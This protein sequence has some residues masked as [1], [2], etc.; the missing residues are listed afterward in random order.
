MT[1]ETKQKLLLIVILSF[2]L[3]IIGLSST[4][5]IIYAKLDR[6]Q[7]DTIESISCDYPPPKECTK[8]IEMMEGWI[9]V[10]G[11]LEDKWSNCNRDLSRCQNEMNQ[12]ILCIAPDCR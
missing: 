4:T 3:V 11:K 7:Q 1:Y 6:C 12:D 5:S 9:K 8:Y 10:Y 2:A